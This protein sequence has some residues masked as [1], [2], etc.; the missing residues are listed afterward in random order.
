MT[1]E[2]DA[3]LARPPLT[4]RLRVSLLPIAAVGSVIGAVKYPE[5]GWLGA[6]IAGAAAMLT[7]ASLQA[8][9]PRTWTPLFCASRLA[10]LGLAVGLGISWR[11]A[12]TWDEWLYAPPLVAAGFGLI[13]LGFW[14][15]ARTVRAIAGAITRAGTPSLSIDAV[16][17]P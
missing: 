15:V 5:L 7:V 1:A 17:H 13:G 12:V 9:D 14:L 2:P 10:G 8:T 11:F 4:P 16:E 3:E 6:P